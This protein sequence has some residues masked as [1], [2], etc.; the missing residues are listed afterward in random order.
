[1]FLAPETTNSR[2]DHWEKKVVRALHHRWVLCDRDFEGI[3]L[4]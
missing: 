2:A 3:R 1:M 4:H